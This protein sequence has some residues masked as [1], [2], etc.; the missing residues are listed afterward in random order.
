[1]KILSWYYRGLGSPQ[2]VRALLRLIHVGNPDLVFI[3]ESRLKEMRVGPSNSKVIWSV[4]MVCI[5]V[6][7]VGRDLVDLPCCG[8]KKFS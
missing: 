6:A 2:A 4:V 7:M 1:M 8:R 5:A 3:M